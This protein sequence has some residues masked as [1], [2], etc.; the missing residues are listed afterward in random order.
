MPPSLRG[1]GDFL[2]RWR[3]HR[4]RLDAGNVNVRVENL[5]I[6]NSIESED[7]GHDH[8][9]KMLSRISGSSPPPLRAID[10]APSPRGRLA[11]VPVVLSSAAA[12]TYSKNLEATCDDAHQEAS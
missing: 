1:Y 10:T 5:E 8:H 12:T 11:E 7:S 4:A 3:I 9:D 2:T 6:V